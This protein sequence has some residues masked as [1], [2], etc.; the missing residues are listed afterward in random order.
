VAWQYSSGLER[1]EK[2]VV[3][4]AFSYLLSS[5]ELST[6]KGAVWFGACFWRG[7]MAPNL[8]F[9]YYLMQ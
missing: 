6:V 7:A 5:N 4:L 9:I 8:K 1:K 3:G 2:N